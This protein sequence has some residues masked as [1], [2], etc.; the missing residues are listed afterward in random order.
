MSVTAEAVASHASCDNEIVKVPERGRVDVVT[1]SLIVKV[2]TIK[3][4]KHDDE[5]RFFPLNIIALFLELKLF[6]SVIG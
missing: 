6:P 4:N 3:Q 2:G 1:R 5:E